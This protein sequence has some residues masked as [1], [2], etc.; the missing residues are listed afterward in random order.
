MTRVERI[1]AAVERVRELARGLGSPDAIRAF[2]EVTGEILDALP[3]PRPGLGD[4]T[5]TDTTGDAAST[6]TPDAS[7]VYITAPAAGAIA[8][9]ALLA[10]AGAGYVIRGKLDESK[11][12]PRKVRGR[13]RPREIEEEAAE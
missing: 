8:G 5:T 1:Q 4:S 2:D 6:A 10:G 9:I 7:Q 12:G 13:R 11:R 3:R